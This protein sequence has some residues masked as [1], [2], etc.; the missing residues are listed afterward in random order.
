MPERKRN[1]ILSAVQ[2]DARERAGAPT[3]RRKA[4]QDSALELLAEA[5]RRGSDLAVLPEAL[6]VYA[7]GAR[8]EAGREALRPPRAI[9][10]VRRAAALARRFRMNVAVPV[11]CLDEGGLPRNACV[12]LDRRGA[13]AGRYEKVHPTRG[14]RVR[15]GIVPGERFAPVALDF[16]PVGAF[17]CHD[18]SFQES[19]RCQRLAGAELL[20]WPHVQSAWGDIVWDITLRSR[21][22]DNEV[23]LVSSCFSV[24]GERAWR[25]GMMMG[26]SNVIGRDG[27]ILAEV[28]RDPGV[29]TAQM[30][31]AARRLV[32]SFTDAE[33]RP[34]WDAI[35]M[36]RRPDAYGPI[37]R[38]LGTE[39]G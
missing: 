17:I 8:A 1:V 11:L 12:F 15:W 31:L 13:I 14:E 25:P 30:D 16:G 10:V 19:A 9:P 24:R 7:S 5:G 6:N 35:C 18:M 22:V 34:L 32:H 39:K 4:V 29:A 26:R 27:F 36:D 33:D 38:P 28:S 20:V 3:A 23:P 21:A 2:P 37:T